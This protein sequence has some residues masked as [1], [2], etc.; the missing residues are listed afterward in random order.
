M[1]NK[2]LDSNVAEHFGHSDF[3]GLYDFKN[4]KLEIKENRLD[5]SN[6]FSSP[7]DQVKEIFNPDAVYA[8]ALGKRAIMLFKEKGIIIITGKFSKVK[9]IILDINNCVEL[10]RDCGH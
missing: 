10:D 6:A 7:I 5:H 4:K 2:G 3:L 1:D 8:F 9:D